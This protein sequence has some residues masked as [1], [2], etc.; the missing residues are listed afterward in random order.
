MR[1]EERIEGVRAFRSENGYDD[2]LSILRQ[3]IKESGISIRTNTIVEGIDWG[4]RPATVHV[5]DERGKSSI[6]ASSVLVTV[7]LGVLKAKSGPHGAIQFDPPLPSE[8][9]NALDKLEMG[10][11]IRVVL[12]FRERFWENIQPSPGR[13]LA[14]MSF[15]FSQD[16]WFPTWWTT[17]PK[18][19]PI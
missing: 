1:G 17:I 4:S 12:R 6:L 13:S 19:Y 5:S 16:E 7:P 15:L 10:E 11:V 9:I 18:K 14:N 8:K 3:Q 2:L